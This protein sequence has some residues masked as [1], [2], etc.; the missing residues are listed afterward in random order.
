MASIRRHVRPVCDMLVLT[1]IKNCFCLIKTFSV[2]YF[3]MLMKCVS[4]IIKRW[5]FDCLN[6]FSSPWRS[7]SWARA[8]VHN[9][10][11]HWTR[12]IMLK[13]HVELSTDTEGGR[14]SGGSSFVKLFECFYELV[15]RDT[16]G[17]KH[18]L[19]KPESKII[20]MFWTSNRLHY[21]KCNNYKKP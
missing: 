15:V 21:M 10:Y 17:D 7:W 8:D 16:A 2:M 14:G 6:C 18:K 13:H 1:F 9:M 20:L 4:V 5:S 19:M 3:L 12:I 11:W